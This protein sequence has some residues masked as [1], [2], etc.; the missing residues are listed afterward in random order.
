MVSEREL[1]DG[2]KGE[3]MT[4]E[5]KLLERNYNYLLECVQYHELVT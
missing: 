5:G 3:D 2:D 4:D 1:G